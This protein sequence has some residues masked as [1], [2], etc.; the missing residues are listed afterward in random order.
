MSSPSSDTPPRRR[1]AM[2]AYT[3]YQTDPRCRREAELCVEAGWEVD[4]YALRSTDTGRGK[5]LRGVNLI[6]VPMDR[7][8]GDSAGAYILSYV[9]FLVLTLF[10]LGD[11]HLTRHYA[12]TH[13]NTMPDFMVFAALV[14]RLGGSKVILDIH[15]VM[16]EIY[17]T[18]F[19]LPA[20]HWKIR[21]IRW[22]EVLSAKFAHA[23]LAAEHP[24]GELVIEH[25]VPRDK[26]QVL[27]N[28]PDERIFP[29][30]SEAP[31]DLPA[32]PGDPFRLIYHGTLAE[33]LGLDLAIRA[34]P[35]VRERFPGATLR[36]IGDGDH[37]PELHRLTDELGLGGCVS[38]SDAF[39]PI[40]D[41]LPELMRGHLAV[42]PTRHEVSTDYMLPTKFIEYLRL[43][44]PSV[45][46]PTRT[47]RHYFG[48]AHPL[49]I[50]DPT[51][52]TVAER[53]LWVRENPE[54]A[55]DLTGELQRGFFGEFDWPEHKWT[56]IELLDRLSG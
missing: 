55:H 20:D 22:V 14:P 33:R 24:K 53:I 18:K 41:I 34:L 35:I 38:F 25:G 11:R 31:A 51:P 1:I 17:M 54:E 13:V 37:L 8:R 2:V 42:I 27:L 50:E 47:V 6:E 9:R 15:D 29:L 43:G 21:L 30:R 4:F 23:V 39:L 26:V 10:M 28:L 40:E 19:R 16:P 12:V 36:I 45:V 32:A 56:Y 44:V 49:Y 3:H 5:D 48:D 52:E 7:Y 46:T